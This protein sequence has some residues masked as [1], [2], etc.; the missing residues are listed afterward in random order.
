[1]LTTVTCWF[2]LFLPNQKPSSPIKL[3][4]ICLFLPL[5][6]KRSKK[7]KKQLYQNNSANEINAYVV[8]HWPKSEKNH[9]TL[10]WMTYNSRC[11]ILVLQKN[12]DN[13]LLFVVDQ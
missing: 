9:F 10:Q 11:Q 2:S 3:F 4:C 8:E 6:K 5:A 7:I 12:K 13:Q 1:M